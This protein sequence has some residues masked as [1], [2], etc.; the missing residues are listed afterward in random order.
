MRL[1]P[2]LNTKDIGKIEARVTFE[3]L[4]RK[5]WN[6]E[7]AIVGGLEAKFTTFCTEK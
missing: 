1:R 2:K 6:V 4:R 3:T 5:L 7:N